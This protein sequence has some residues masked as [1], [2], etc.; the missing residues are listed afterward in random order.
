[1]SSPA[2]FID[3]PRWA[4]FI[5]ETPDAPKRERKLPAHEDCSRIDA[6]AAAAHIAAGG[7]L[8]AMPGYEE[9][10]GQIDMLKAVAAAF[11][12][13]EHLM[14][15][16]GT[17]VGKSIA[18]LIPSILWAWTNDTPVVV[19]T[20]TR[21]LQSQ[22]ME[23]DIPKAVSVLGDDAAS[24]KAALLKGRAN[25][26]CL[27]A[28]DDFF[29]PGYWTMSEEEKAEMPRFIEWLKTTKDGDL[30]TYDGLP[31]Q[32]MSCPSEE[33][34]GRR[35]RFRSRCFVQKARRAA[36]DA[37]L[38]VANHSLVL[39]EAANGAAAI[40]PAYARLV[41]DEAHNLEQI[42]TDCLCWM[43]SMDTLSALLNRL[44]RSPRGKRGRPG[45]ILA[46]VERMMQKGAFAGQTGAMAA[47]K[48]AYGAM[49]RV[50]D[51]ADAAMSVASRMFGP[52]R[53]RQCV[54]Y[55]FLEGR[56]RYSVHGLFREY[57]DGE[58]SEAD[59]R[60]A[61]TRLE[62]ELAG[63]VN[64]IHEI[65]DAVDDGAEAGENDISVQLS[66]I[67]ESIVSFASEVHF[68]I[69]G[70]D[71]NYAYWIEKLPPRGKAKGPRMRLVAAPLSVAASLESLLYSKKD[72]VVLSSATLRVGS[73]FKYMSKRLGCA[74][75]FRAMAAQSPFDY[76]RQCRALAADW[77]P[78]PSA[79]PGGYSASLAGMLGGL[80]GAS[81][82]RALVLFT[83]YEMMK[84]VA[85][86]AR[87]ELESRGFEL[88][89]QGEGVSRE[90]MTKAL[91]SGGR[92]VLF[93]A[94]S[95]WEGVDVA[96]EALSCVVIARLPFAQVGDPIIEAR[97]EKIARDGG[98]A[99][100]EYALPEA[101][102]RFRQGFGR[103]VRTKRDRGVVVIT[104]PRLMTKNYG[105]IF[106]KSIPAPV[107]AV[108]DPGELSAAVEEFFREG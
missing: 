13:R 54:R 91:K 16:A 39:S 18:Y 26:L 43:F 56:R 96:G 63:L 7:T 42:A 40:L 76:F 32:L 106:R 15:E 31:R 87:P 20:A 10:P 53:D 35:C 45:G 104:D 52:A 88:L 79:D 51:A 46:S 6:E 9:R 65:R 49:V 75:R 99:F 83:S 50:K 66:S 2:R 33:C 59:M 105:A 81:D 95:F 98:S 71:E 58:W 8:G 82:A 57:A 34:A 11:N 107:H 60:H 97:S 67:C 92:T 101:V 70:E 78:D 12:A 4:D 84:D 90:S 30:D 3:D 85:A 93:G 64:S 72:S 108:S 28:I 94:Q 62:N 38:V 77:L 74:E 69:R 23:S 1:M 14:I 48:D 36:A 17:G 25:Y 68:T 55:K 27:R 102:I 37:H 5:P 89:V 19:S 80:L 73:D 24:F 61:E 44:S 21:N 47:L 41:L 86:A 103:L 22:L 100:R 29:S